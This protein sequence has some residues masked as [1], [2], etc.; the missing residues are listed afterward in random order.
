MFIE[1]ILCNR[2]CRKCFK[3]LFY[4]MLYI[5][6]KCVFTSEIKHSLQVVALSF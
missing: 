4:Y 2:H 1:N 5:V 6:C 3:Y